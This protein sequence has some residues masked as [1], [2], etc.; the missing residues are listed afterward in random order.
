MLASPAA[1]EAEVLARLGTP[2]W[3][4]DKYDGIRAQLHAADREV[5][6][7]SR[8]LHDVS[9]QFP[10]V[11]AAAAA[12]LPGTASS[13][14]RCSPGATARR[15]RSSSSRR[16]L[17]RKKPSAAMQAATPVIFVAFDLLALAARRAAHRS[18]RCCACRCASDARGWTDSDL[19]RPA[20]LRDV[21]SRTAADDAAALEAHLRRRA[22]R[23]ATR[24]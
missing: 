7:Y 24:G 4:E 6:L 9:G 17:G 12:T 13:T 1:D 23:A 10:E 22:Q 20:R 21:A 19:R 2:V 8:D 16:R 15:C 11:V 3:V 18:S 14:A 5:R